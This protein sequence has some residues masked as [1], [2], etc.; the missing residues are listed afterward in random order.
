ML[1]KPRQES[2]ETKVVKWIALF[3]KKKEEY[4]MLLKPRQER[5]ETKVVKWI[6]LFT[7]TIILQKAVVGFV[8]IRYEH[9]FARRICPTSNHPH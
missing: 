1:L 3:T 6:A 7:K 2:G 5:G 8:A 9:L 4:L